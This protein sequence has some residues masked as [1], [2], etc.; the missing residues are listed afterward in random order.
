M[1][2]DLKSI[3]LSYIAGLL[4][5]G[6]VA[7]ISRKCNSFEECIMALKILV[8]ARKEVRLSVS[9]LFR[10]EIENKYLLIKGNR[11]EQ[12]QPVG[13]V[14]KAYRSAEGLFKKI[15]VKKDNGIDIDG[16][17]EN[18]LRIKVKSK[19]VLSFI[20]WFKER[21]N[22]E[23]NVNREFYEEL[24][25]SNFI[26]KSVLETF[27][28]EYLK[29]VYT[30]LK[31][32]THFKCYEILIYDIFEIKL[33]SQYEEMLKNEINTKRGNLILATDD[34]IESENIKIDGI[35]KKIGEH[36]KYII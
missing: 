14:Y 3:M 36:S 16:A 4:T 9:Y 10:I 25:V 34:E 15:E 24:V 21:K 5:S 23:I 33:D 17:S 31:Y 29:T 12:F 28:P 22:R 32:S 18:D 35:S 11:I 27:S 20:R 6:T 7:F 19:N 8:K 1:N 30:D 13:G 2:Q 26:D